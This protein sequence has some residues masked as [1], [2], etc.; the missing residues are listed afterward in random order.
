MVDAGSPSWVTFP[1]FKEFIAKPSQTEILT[2]IH[3]SGIGL[4]YGPVG[5]MHDLAYANPGQVAETLQ[6]HRDITVGVKVRQGKM[7]VGDNGVEPLK[8]AIQAAEQAGTPVMCHIGAG[9]PL[10]DVLALLRPGDVL[11][12]CFQGNG[13][14]IVDEKG[15]VIPEAWKARDDGVI[16]D[17]G[18]GGGSFRYEIAQRAMEQGFISDVI[19]TDLH[20]GNINGPVYDLPTTLSKIMHLGLSLA[21]VIEKA[22]FSAAKAIRREAQLGHLKIGTVADVAVFELLEGEF[23]F[24]DS[25]GTKFIGDKKLKSVLTIRE[26]RL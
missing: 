16:F 19:S 25:H 1:G 2:Y 7:Q 13:D 26:G 20:T 15:R 6:K 11:T 17:V 4:I 5:E 23:A 12:H 10:P 3:I 9:V 18:H 22:T 21:E 8:L 24:F 14:N